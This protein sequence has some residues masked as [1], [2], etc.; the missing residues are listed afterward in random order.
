MLKFFKCYGFAVLGNH[1]YRGDAVAQLSPVLTNLDKRW[2]CLRSYV[3]DAGEKKL[4]FF[5]LLNISI[6]TESLIKILN[7]STNELMWLHNFF[8]SE[9]AEFFFVDTTPFVEKYFTE[10]KDH[11]YDWRGVLPRKEYMSNLLKVSIPSTSQ[12]INVKPSLKF[13]NKQK[14]KIKSWTISY[15]LR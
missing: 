3:V 15:N 11:V 14:R 12:N 6:Y 13:E 5:F 9:V 10:P 2:V 8:V 4:D 1:D 7:A